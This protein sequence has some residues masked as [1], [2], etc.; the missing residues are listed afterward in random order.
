MRKNE[1]A[2]HCKKQLE[3]SRRMLGAQRNNTKA[4]F[5]FYDAD[6]SSYKDN[7]QFTDVSG[8]KKRAEV[9]F[10]QIKASVD[11]VGGFMAQNRR[12]AKFIARIPEQPA[13]SLY[14]KYKNALY[15]YVRDNTNADQLET[16]Q[17]LDNLKCGYGAIETDLSYII[18]NAT[19]NPYGEILKMKLDPDQVGWDARAKETNL[20]DAKYVYYWNDYPLKDALDLF[21][22]SKED[23]FE[24]VELEDNGGYTYNPYGGVYDRIKELNTVEWASKTDETV[25]VYNH[26][27]M[28]YET[29]YRSENPVNLTDD[30]DLRAFMIAKLEL[31]AEQAKDMSPEG[32]DVTDMFTLDPEGRELVFDD[33][34]KSK[35]IAEFG[36]YINPIP[37]KRKC[38]YTAV[39]SG[40]HT[41]TY[42]KSISQQGFSVKFKTGAYNKTKKIWVGMINSMMEPQKYYNKYLTEL[43]FII[44]SNSK[45]GVMIE[46]DAVHDITD[47]E[48]NYAR[49]DAVIS[50]KSGALGQGKIQAKAVPQVPTG[51]ENIVQLAESAITKNGVD[52]SFMGAIERQDQ[53]GILYKRRIRQVISRFAAYFDSITLYQKEDARLCSDLMR[54]W[55]QNN[56]GE[57]VQITGDEGIEEFVQLN[58]DSMS[59]E[60]DVSIQEAPQSPEDKQETAQL[61]NSFGD[62]YLTTGDRQT[63]NAFFMESLSFLGIDGDV[64]SR[65]IEAMRPQESVPMEQ[66]QQLQQQFQAL[67]EQLNGQMAQMQMAKTQADID[68]IQSDVAKNQAEMQ[69]I[70]ADIAKTLEEAASTGLQ[71]D[72]MREGAVKEVNLTI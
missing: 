44:A 61:L 72:F 45:G 21:E 8:K 46:E 10:N 34:L 65:L 51:I 16:A 3:E 32:L 4:C 60:Y 48:K 22:G 68:K 19:T 9:V 70:G 57:F 56:A 20:L 40:S 47:F 64:K 49:T 36:E 24:G 50:V 37:F 23:N 63:A 53:S 1:V 43:M 28:E 6:D 26:Q 14:S 31:I 27:W 67:Q 54:I 69:K 55:V 2:S 18:G 52:P 42:F 58:E 62:K 12:Q 66:F 59:A 38:F 15:Q 13:Q 25:R 29:F 33:S 41:F 7:I 30:P 11:A 5:A 35:L 17:D 71:N 39:Y